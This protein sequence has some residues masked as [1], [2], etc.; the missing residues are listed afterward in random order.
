LRALAGGGP[1]DAALWVAG[2]DSASP[3]RR[4]AEELG[5]G[6][7][8][9]FLGRRGDIEDVYAAADALIL[10]TRY[11]AFANVCLEAA[12]SGL[13]VVTSGSN[14]AA[15]WIGE[16]GLVIDD[17]EDFA[18]FAKALDALADPTTREQLGA[19]ARRRAEALGWPE[20]V[21]ALRGLYE[22]VCRRR[23]GCR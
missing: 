15:R 16:A 11:D 3:W 20:H 19:A 22:R 4:L 5:V 23:P 8:V 6:S 10:P 14:G 2:S 13:A 17:P 18:G 7:R 9:R 12:A 21:R 1:A